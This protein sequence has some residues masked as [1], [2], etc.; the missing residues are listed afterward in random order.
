MLLAY[1]HPFG[2]QASRPEL[3]LIP[4]KPDMFSFPIRVESLCLTDAAVYRLGPTEGLRVK[5]D[6][7]DQGV[8]LEPVPPSRLYLTPSQPD[9]PGFIV[10]AAKI[11][12][13]GDYQYETFYTQ[14][15]RPGEWKKWF[16][17]DFQ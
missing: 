14:E 3:C 6:P 1:I 16:P 13:L 7:G 4:S 17:N 9:R 10:A 12:V 2:P 15:G 5:K 8:I 11:V